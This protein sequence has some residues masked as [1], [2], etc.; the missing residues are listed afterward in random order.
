MCCNTDK[1]QIINNSSI[2]VFFGGSIYQTR[3]CHSYSVQ[4]N[5]PSRKLMS[6]LKDQIYKLLTQ[7]V[8]PQKESSVKLYLP[9]AKTTWK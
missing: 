7:T 8:G 4:C 9:N 2:I 1:N 3:V 5:H 6:H